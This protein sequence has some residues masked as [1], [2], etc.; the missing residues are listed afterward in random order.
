MKSTRRNILKFALASAALPVT[1]PDPVR[2]QSIDTARILS[3]FAAGG[4][5]DT[6]A[7][8]VA[9]KLRGNYA[10]A[11]VV[12]TRAGAGGQIAIQ[13]LKMALP[14]GKTLL[15]TPM[16]M[17]GIY[18][19]TY[20][21]LGYDPVADLS[22]VSLGVVFDFGFAVGPMV[23]AD[24]KTV[25][26]FIA[27]CKA[28]PTQAN[29][30]SPAAG[31]VPHFVGELL[32]RAGRIDLRHVAFRGSQPAIL[33]MLGGQIASVS[34]PMGEFLPH[35]PGG[36][37]RFLATS[38]AKRNRFAPDV[39]TLAEQGFKDLVFDEWFG[40]YLPGKAP[41]EIV[42]KANTDIRAALATSDV[43]NGL[44]TMG[45]E[46]KSSS[47]AELAARLKADS[48]RWAP[49]VKEIGFTAES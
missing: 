28:N 5:V 4:T 20:R 39:P 1:F 14:D 2:A 45:L 17:L 47:P 38:G 43:I 49:I 13:T 40:F 21:K 32:G 29:F 12:D 3:G 16:S 11:V 48:D 25:P 34:A 7:R 42:S 10:K 8:R 37:V 18:P 46:A 33:D 30:G 27:W 35:V 26:D 22:P 41:A 31:S 19:H 44:A 6:L 9:D 23:P 15:A 36:K 24:V